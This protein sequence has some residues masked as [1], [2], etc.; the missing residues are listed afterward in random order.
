[1]WIK[2]VA[3]VI[4]AVGCLDVGASIAVVKLHAR[5]ISK[6]GGP[7]L[8]SRHVVG[9][10]SGHSLLV[11]AIMLAMLDLLRIIDLP[12][13]SYL[14]PAGLGMLIT[15]AAVL[16]IGSVQRSRTRRASAREAMTPT[17]HRWR[18]KP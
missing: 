1:M 11:I 9:V 14:I 4:L 8:I 18:K 10:A 6:S 13:L 17:S 12:L 5:A 2:L 7:G 3:L 16:I 15:F